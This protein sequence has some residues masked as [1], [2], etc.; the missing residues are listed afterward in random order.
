[1]GVGRL[2]AFCIGS[3]KAVLPPLPHRSAAVPTVLPGQCCHLCHTDQQL[4]PHKPCLLIC[5]LVLLV[6][7]DAVARAQTGRHSL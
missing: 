1:M 6:S 5:A 4:S 7:A 2:Y 3:Q